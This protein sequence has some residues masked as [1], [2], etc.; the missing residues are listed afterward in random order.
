MSSV[1]VYIVFITFHHFSHQCLSCP[2][3][4][5][6]CLSL[7][8]SCLI[9]FHHCAMAF[10]LLMFIDVHVFIKSHQCSLLFEL[11]YIFKLVYIT[12]PPFKHVSHWKAW[13]GGWPRTLTYIKSYTHLLSSKMSKKPRKQKTSETSTQ[14]IMS[15]SHTHVYIY[16]YIYIYRHIDRFKLIGMILHYII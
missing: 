15:L 10:L 12:N 8:I 16:I 4:F 6:L 7:F 5:L 11:Y 1:F 2:R 3:C 9:H 14:K 13:T